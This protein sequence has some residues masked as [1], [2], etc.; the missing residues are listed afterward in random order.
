MDMTRGLDFKDKSFDVI[1][2]FRV[3]LH[4]RGKTIDELL[5]KL[6]NLLKDEGY[7]YV[8]APV[9]RD[10]GEWEWMLK[11]IYWRITGQLTPV[12]AKCIT[13]DGTKKILDRLGFSYDIFYVAG[14]KEERFKESSKAIFRI[15][16]RKI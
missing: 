14:D 2:L 11:R 7:I 8:D 5:L 10:F 1:F 13:R 16:K 9:K 12:S 6:S 4:L 3:L 15:R